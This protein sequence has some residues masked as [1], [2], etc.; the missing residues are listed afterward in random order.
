MAY[1]GGMIYFVRHGQSQANVDNVFAGPHYP[2]PLTL[3]GKQQA[4]ATANDIL[5]Q[6]LKID[7]ILT[8]PLERARQT[9]DIIALAIGFNP[10]EIKV[11]PELQ[12]YDMGELSGKPMRNITSKQLVSAPEAED[13]GA[14]RARVQGALN[15]AG[16]LPGNT[17][18]VSHAGVGRMIETIKQNLDPSLFYDLPSHPN[19]GVVVIGT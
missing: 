8:S 15:A 5:S 10:S 4:K 17:L 13:P 19:G 1:N 7:H 12:E 11:M 16:Q 9:A 6:H 3:E 2:A 14:F 18:I